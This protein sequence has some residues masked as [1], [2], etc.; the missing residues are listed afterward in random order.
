MTSD[1]IAKGIMSDIQAGFNMGLNISGTIH[2]ISFFKF[3]GS[4]KLTALDNGLMFNVKRGKG[5]VQVRSVITLNGND[6]YDIEF[7]T[8]RQFESKK[9]NEVHDVYSDQLTAVLR[10][11]LDI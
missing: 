10:K 5:R 7:Y 9:I 2:K 6:T 1:T 3:C 8:V 11:E 4:D